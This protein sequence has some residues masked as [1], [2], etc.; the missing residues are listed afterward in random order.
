MNRVSMWL[1]A[2]LACASFFVASS[3]A[4]QDA[5]AG[6]LTR[7]HDGSIVSGDPS[8]SV[9]K[10]GNVCYFVFTSASTENSVQ[11]LVTEYA[12]VR[13]QTDSTSTG[14]G[15]GRVTLRKMDGPGISNANSYEN[16]TVMN[17][18]LAVSDGSDTYGLSPGI[19]YAVI[20]TAAAAGETY[21][22]TVQGEN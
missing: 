9:I 21:V 15:A 22:M 19:Y 16:S 8:C 4:A 14:A 13:F 10:P 2:G 1:L 3:A 20:Q 7:R 17:G 18:S 6:A 11:F 5:G 12:E